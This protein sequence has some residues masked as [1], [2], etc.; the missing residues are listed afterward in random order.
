MKQ[1]G[2]SQ[3]GLLHHHFLQPVS[4]TDAGFCIDN[5]GA[6][7]AGNLPYAKFQALAQRSLLA[8]T[9]K[10]VAH[11]GSFAVLT[12]FRQHQPPGMHLGIFFLGRHA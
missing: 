12:I 1:R 8:D 5:M 9:G 7:R 2:Y 11:V 4:R 6:Q 3:T 10:L